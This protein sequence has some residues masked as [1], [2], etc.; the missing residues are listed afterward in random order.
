MALGA[1]LAVSNTR[2]VFEGLFSRDLT[3]ERTP[4]PGLQPR[5]NAELA[6]PTYRV[7]GAPIAVVEIVLV[8]YLFLW[9]ILGTGTEV[10]ADVPFL[11]FFGFGLLSMALPSLRAWHAAR[12][13]WLRRGATSLNPAT[14]T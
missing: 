12:S 13:T 7:P 2:A 5:G 8:V 4:K 3:F 9:K 14:S 6:R 1:G 11:L 10:V